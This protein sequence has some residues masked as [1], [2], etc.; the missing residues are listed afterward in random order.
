MERNELAKENKKD[1]VAK[2][3][4]I[5]DIGK[6]ANV[7]ISTVSRVINHQGGV[8]P[9]LERRVQEVIEQVNYRPNSI[10]QALKSKATRLIGTI[11]PSVNNPIFS[12]MTENYAA[13]AEEYGYS[14]ITCSS[15]SSVEKEVKCLETLVK[16]QV[17][18]IIFNG[19]GI[20]DTRFNMVNEA[21]V[22]TVFIGRRMEEFP[23]DNVTLDNKAGA[24]QAVSHLI[25]NGAKKIG[26]IFGRNESVS[27]T[28]DR[29][30]GY[31]Q[32]LSDQEIPFDESLVIR[33]RSEKDDGGRDA[34]QQLLEIAPRVD[35]IF[36]SNDLMALGCMDQLRRSGISVPDQISV[37]GYDGIPYGEFLTPPLSTM[38]TPVKEMAQ[39]SVE[40]LIEKI[41]HG[42]GPQREIVFQPLLLIRGSTRGGR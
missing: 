6:M 3:A 30:A 41:E 36:A 10:A 5:L 24:Y 32:A 34:T 19:M 12:V 38:M 4:T 27:A 1:T 13:V 23:C 25:R 9:E 7:S 14:L 28:D 17:D 16:H 42:Q 37:M 35:S 22:P 15:N 2:A 31:Q 21:Q 20:F 29:F 40:L 11:V 26:F 33:T 8:S 39:R 18:G